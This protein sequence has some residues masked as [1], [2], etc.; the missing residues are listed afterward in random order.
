[1]MQNLIPLTSEAFI[2]ATY[3][4]DHITITKKMVNDYL[5]ALKRN[6]VVVTFHEGDK[7][8]V[9]LKYSWTKTD[10]A[11]FDFHVDE[12]P[13][14]IRGRMNMLRMLGPYKIT[15]EVGYFNEFEDEYIVFTSSDELFEIHKLIEERVLK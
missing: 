10:D 13:I 7:E 6:G 9:Y 1:M 12:L 2:T 5:I 11:A 4:F 15:E 8:R 14:F 3:K